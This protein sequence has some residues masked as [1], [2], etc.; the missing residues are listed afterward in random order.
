MPTSARGAVTSKRNTSESCANTSKVSPAAGA[1]VNAAATVRSAAVLAV[2]R[3]SSPTFA[4]EVKR[5]QWR[6]SAY[7]PAVS[8]AVDWTTVAVF[9]APAVSASTDTGRFI[10]Q[11][12]CAP[13]ATRLAVAIVSLGSSSMPVGGFH[14]VSL[15]SSV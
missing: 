2:M 7:W 13:S 14:E 3:R 15:T 12:S 1:A 4:P 11:P 6:P 9:T 8:T 10:S 5:S